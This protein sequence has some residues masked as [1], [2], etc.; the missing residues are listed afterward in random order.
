MT[1]VI[2]LT[3]NGLIDTRIKLISF[4]LNKATFV[5]LYVFSKLFECHILYWFLLVFLLQK[6]KEEILRFKEYFN[7][8]FKCDLS[9]G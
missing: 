5:K 6:Q 4:F 2:C 7:K 8:K 1:L 3:V 9:K